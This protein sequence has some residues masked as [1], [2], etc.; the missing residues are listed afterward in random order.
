MNTRI[1]WIDNLR[2]CLICLVVLGHVIQFTHPAYGNTLPFQYIYAFHMPLFIFVSGFVSGGHQNCLKRAIQLIVPFVVY[3]LLL[4][5]IKGDVA[6][7]VKFFIYPEKSL[8]FLWVLFF[9]T[10]FHQVAIKTCN[11]IKQ[12]EIFGVIAMA[13]LLFFLGN[14]IPVFGIPIIAKFFVYYIIAYYTKPL[15]MSIP[16]N[17]RSSCFALLLFMLFLLL[18]YWSTYPTPETIPFTHTLFPSGVSKLYQIGVALLAIVAFVMC[19]MLFSDRFVRILTRI[20]AR[21]TLGIYAIHTLA[22][23]ICKHPTPI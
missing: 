2:F 7:F 15:F 18:A 10:L 17:R 21:D 4:S 5:F 9:I 22:L 1:I 16:K 20:G 8:W 19:F 14:H 3:S 6:R 13:V 11:R 23:N 12:K